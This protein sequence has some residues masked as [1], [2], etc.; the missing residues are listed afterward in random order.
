MTTAVIFPARNHEYVEE[1]MMK[2]KEMTAIA[3]NRIWNLVQSTNWIGRAV[4]ALFVAA[5]LLQS[6]A[7]PAVAQG[8]NIVILAPHPD[9]E[10]LCCA[11]IIHNAL[12]QGSSVTIVVVTNGDY[13]QGVPLGLQREAETV[14]AMSLLGLSEQQI[15]F[16]GYGDEAL[17]GLYQSSSPATVIPSPAGQT[18]TYASRGLGGISY[19]QYL[20]GTPGPYSRQTILG[21][22]EAMLQNLQP[23]DVYTTGLW[24]DHPD[25]VA[26][27]NF[28]VE[29]LLDLRRQ[30]LPLSTKIHETLV[31]A[32]CGSCGVPTNLNYLWP[33]GGTGITPTFSPTQPYPQP[34]YLSNAWPNGNTPTP[35]SWSQ[36]E[37]VPVPAPMQDP[38]QAT[39]FKANIIA[40]YKS[41]DGSDRNAYLYAFVKKNEFFWIR[42][43]STNL[44]GLATVS[45][46]TQS[47]GSGQL[48]TS[49]VDGFIE[50]FP[51]YAPWEWVTQ[52]ELAGAWINL[53]WPSPV[54]ISQVVLY[55]RQDWVDQ[56]LSG[57]L[58][59]SDNS[60]VPVGQLPIS[61]NGY[62]VSFPPK[63]VTSM[64]FTVDSGTGQNIGLTEIEVFGELAG[65]TVN[66]PQFFQ[67]PLASAPYGTDQ[68]GQLLT[69]TI[70]DSQTTNL[71]VLAFDV[72]AQ[73]LNYSWT[74]DSGIVTGSG[75]NALFKPPVVAAPTVVTTT[76]ALDDGQG[77]TAQNSTFITVTPSNTSG[78]TVS[79]L[80]VSPGSVQ[81]GST[82]LGTVTLSNVA[83]QGAVVVLSSSNTAIANVPPTVAV[84]PGATSATF[85]ISTVYVAS[86]VSVTISASLGGVT[87][88]DS[89]TVLQ[90]PVIVSSVTFNP[91]TVGGGN[92]S[93]GT[94]LLTGPAQGDAVITLTNGSPS[95]ITIPASVTVPSG[96][97]SVSFPVTTQSVSSATSVAISALYVGQ[98]TKVSLRVAPYV[99]PNLATSATVTVSSQSINTQQQGIKA[100][101]GIVDGSP[102]D[103]TEEW[104]TLGQLAGA[105]LKLSW[106][107]PVTTSQVVLYDRPNL[108][109]NVT[110]ATLSF[111]DG[112][113]VPVGTLP[114]DGSPLAVSFSPKT[115]TWMQFTVNTAV[116]QNIGL[117]EIAVMGTI[118]QAS[119]IMSLT[120]APTSVTGGNGSTGTVTLDGVAPAGGS[121]VALASSDTSTATVP[122]TVTVPAGSLAASFP[123]ATNSVAS[124]TGVSISGT[125]NGTQAALLTVVPVGISTLS[126]S[127]AMVAGGAATST[128]TVTLTGPAPPSGA[129]IA[130]TSNN[131]SVASVPATMAIPPGSTSGTFTVTTTSVVATVKVGVSAIYNGIQAATLWVTPVISGGTM[132]QFAVDNFNRNN[133]PLGSD[134]STTIESPS[135]P[136]ITSQQVQS[137]WVFSTALYYGGI[138]WPADQYAQVQVLQSNNGSSGPAVRMTS[139]AYYAGTV[140]SFGAGNANVYIILNSRGNRSIIASSSTATVLA[141]DYLQLTV[142]GTTLTLT[143]VTQSETLLTVTDSTLAAGYP[144]L[145]VGSGG[146]V[147]NWSAGL[148]AM[149]PL[150]QTI[151][152]D[153]FNRADSPNLG[154][155]WSVG[156]GY[157]PIQIISTQIE[158]D[159]QGQPPGQGHGKEYYSAATFPSDQWSQAQ[160][161]QS[162]NDIN[163]A[164]VRY[165][166]SADTHYVGFASMLGAPGTCSVAIDS[167]TNGSPTVLAADSQLCSV[168]SGDYLRLQA[169]GS[170]L[171]Y[172]DVTTG[173][174]LLTV[175]D[176]GLS[177]GYPGWSLNPIGGTP[178]AANW[179]AGQ[180]TA[181]SEVALSSLTLNP[182]SVAGGNTSSGT[183]MLNGPAPS[184]GALVT[185][186]SSNTGAAQLPASVT[187]A[188]GATTATFTIT[189]SGVASNTT[190]TISGSYGATQNAT[191]TVTAAT[192]S[193]VSVNPTSVLGGN[194]STGTVTLNG[195]APSGGAGIALSSS[196][197]SAAQVPTSVT[198]AAGATTAIFAITT[199][200]VASDTTLTISGTYG[201]TQ[202]AS[203]TVTAPRTYTI[204]GTISGP[205]GAGATV[206]L[207]GASTATTTADG[208]GN[209]SFMGLLNGSY[210]VTPS[211]TGYVF[212]PASQPVTISGASATASFSSTLQT[213]SISGTIS[214]AGGAG[215]TVS[216]TGAS[217]AVT[218][219]DGS[220]NYNFSGLLN[221]SYVVTPIKTGYVFTPVSQIVVINGSNFTGLNFSPVSGCPTCDTIWPA[222][223]LPTL[224]DSGDATATEVGVKFRADYDGYITGLRFYK[225]STNTG[226]HVG[227]LWTSTGTPLG[228]ATFTAETV[229]GWQLVLFATPIPVV[230]NTTYVASYF[231]PAGH[232]SGDSDFF[233]TA[234]VDNPPLHALANGLD[235]PDGVYLYTPTGGFPTATNQASNYWVDVVYNNGLGYSIVGTLTGPGAAGATVSLTGAFTATTTADSS[236]NYSFNRLANGSYTVTPS[237]AG[238][239][240]TPASQ[241]LT[242]NG[243]HAMS[244]NFASAPA[245][246]SITGTISGPGGAGATVN[247][248]GASTATTTA[249][250]SGN[251]SFTGLVNGSYT[252]TPTNTG[253]VFAPTSQAVTISGA[254]AVASFSSAQQTYS[255]SGTISG[256]GGAGATVNLTGTSTATTTADGSGNYSFTGLVSGSYTVTPTNTGYMFAP[257]SQAVTVSGANAAASFSST[258]QTFSISGTISG[259]GGAGATVSLTGASTAVTTA[260][261]SGNYTFNGLLNGSYAVTPTNNGYAF[262]PPSQI[263]V[264]NGSNF[265]GLNFSPV[266]G[267]PTCDTIWLATTLPT[268]ADSGDATATELGVKFRA[269]NDGYITGVRFYKASTNTGTHVGHLWTSTGTPLGS[270][271]FTGET[272]AGWQMVLFATPIPVVANTTY[273]ASYFAPAGHYSGDSNFFATA[274]VD[275]PPLH[276]LANGVAGP[277][278]VYLYSPTGG[279]PTATNQASNYWVDVVYNNGLGYSIVGT[280]TGP[281][282]AGA[283]VGLTGASTAT[284]TA[285][286][287]GNYSFNGLANGSYTVTPSNAG[288]VFTPASQTLTINGAHAMNVNFASALQTFSIS[289]TIS[290]PG[291]AGATVNLTGASTAT[292][293]A[294]GSGNYSFAGLANGAYTVTPNLSGYVY[295]PPNQTVTVSG[296][297]ISSV[298]FT[299]VPQTYTISGAIS[300]PGGAGAT[301]SLTGASTATTTAD[302]SGN[303]SFTGLASGSYTVTPSNAGFIFSPPSQSTTISGAN[304]SAFNFNSL[305]TVSSVSVS[306]ASVLG[307]NTSTGTVTLNAPAPA[308]GAVVTLSSGNN[309]A[310]Q[311]PASVTVAANATTATFTVT[312]S[313]VAGNTSLTISA[314]YGTTQTASFTVTAAVLSSVA[315]NPTSVLGGT[316]STGMVTLNG[317]AP[318]GGAVVTL[319]SSNTAAAQVPASVTVAAN[320]TSATFTV[321][322]SPVATNAS[323]TIS[324]TYGATQN[325]TFTVTAAVLSSVTVSPTSVL[326]GTSSTGTVTL[327]GPAPA[328]GAVVTLSSSNTTAAQVVPASV[329]VAANANTATFTVT[330]NPVATNTTLT[331][332]GSYG[333]TQTASFTVT[334]PVLTLLSLNPA[335]VPAGASSVGTVTLSG[336]A[337]AA[338]ALITLSSSNTA[339]AQVPATVTVAARATTV[340]FS[341][342]TS[343]VAANTTLTISGTYGATQNASFTVTSAVLSTVTLNPTSVVGGTSSTGTVTLSKVAPTGGAVVTLVSSNPA[344][345]VPASVTVAA[346]QPIASFTVTTTPVATNT[347]LTISG[348][349]GSTKT[350]ALT[351]AAPT[352]SS[353]TLSPASVIGGTSSTGTVTLNGRAPSGGAV[354]TLS[355]SNTAAAQVPASVTVAANATT[356]TFTVTTSPVATNASVT[357]T[358]TRGTTHTATLTVTAATLSTV[359]MGP[360]SVIGGTPSTGTVT[361]TGPAPSGGAVV[362]LSSS[363]TAAAQVPASVTVAA[364]ATTA[365]FTV[366]T[367]PVATNASVTIT[368]TR[369]TTHTATLTVTAAT[370]SSV[371]LNPTS[372]IGGTSSTGTVTLT[373]P[374]PSGGAVVTLSSSNTSAAKVPAS[375]TVAPNATTATFT[376][377]TSAVASNTS[378]TITGTRGTART[379]TLTVTAPTLSALTLNPT[380]VKGPAP[381]TGTVTLSGPAPTGGTVVTLSSN[382]TSVAT[383]PASVTVTAGTTTA[384]FT[385]TTHTVATSTS[386]TISATKGGTL[387]ANL[388]VTP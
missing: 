186:S 166:G 6:S 367:S 159:G 223:T 337:P 54:T 332:S 194:S 175:L 329:T 300:G 327:N 228:S 359:S 381:S 233:A 23:T 132:Q 318:A 119:T 36:I 253:Y 273:I 213:F 297:S 29:A 209:Y 263:V 215:A 90:P 214:G 16:M 330:T 331:I 374:A 67:G 74:S 135:V 86:S 205:G 168:S 357:I 107:L 277:D 55:N 108:V 68:Y 386:V 156:P 109:D 335:S 251:Y 155:N 313:P 225:A 52:G 252:V 128:G 171:T 76:V 2:D 334:P 320:A 206:N 294:D 35:Y 344:A 384:T 104:A 125:F 247:L 387:T 169:Q 306:P 338:G 380:T 316:S 111:S 101:D 364:N 240:F 272:V 43:F 358:G 183:V 284:T 315:V 260:D 307:G 317:P 178:I 289:G 226:T 328:G 323:L 245:T 254:N 200:A 102:G 232:C 97:K 303:Y 287:S 385:V 150:L 324:G 341:V 204:S 325:A 114:N 161:L 73:P 229:A 262:T 141:N 347:P 196:N 153:N 139:N 173:S 140:G 267:C 47:P 84:A 220:G 163:G 268:L 33:G 177:G 301:V 19:H 286:G 152:S 221:G 224:A 208:S 311:V 56:V 172:V 266:S 69:P 121:V 349:Y 154:P 116:G 142:Q 12:Q 348:T 202:N 248:T 365:T 11:G 256:P 355:S 198:V 246:Y 162:T 143:D 18:Q 235:G 187:V 129:V 77:G 295:T 257:T 4:L 157:F 275:N 72:D 88:T 96:T 179:S 243:A 249:D 302:G 321:T 242:I 346:G 117:A 126:L 62:L 291:G 32:P 8:K 217:T 70:T 383:V 369:S 197:T 230:A 99:P 53:T 319:S 309:A 375:V 37:S 276:A 373:G 87:Q 216:L 370:A 292:T 167:D 145:Y 105:W 110:S 282:A 24:D 201:T 326:G 322:S 41:Q 193:G 192:L 95:I 283:T 241:T 378:V 371:T 379:A 259:G 100:I 237:N 350:A 158:S 244:V 314:T 176:S 343:S 64:Q 51:G 78:L 17:Q 148:T 30:G 340:S 123:I 258:L 61:G 304:V 124:T 269:D 333:A 28:V 360:A 271:T 133:G 219:A 308:G 60:T 98:T 137:P 146:I 113:T 115:I 339:A 164:M 211:N 274:G 44:A 212:T 356:A 63:T 189:T 234:G 296:A 298:N 65:N 342:T 285:D 352:L 25:H 236:G 203:F 7:A 106:G 160:V 21:D 368:A 310:A 83:P 188:A 288:S 131:S 210:T 82:A 278:G 195:P 14:S 27:F 50:G 31:H 66:H 13:Y 3:A 34:Y 15:I 136:A 222:T 26:T 40:S 165:Q 81:S 10:A 362:T 264:I 9:D 363:N 49:A 20:Y 127:P 351:V 91:S 312:T 181:Q 238:Y 218:T 75:A 79:S 280:L 151:A 22:M 354:V 149:P 261:G 147:A 184:G 361:L 377:T 174:L 48:G 185:L 92:P 122:A 46:S 382:L 58:T 134:W 93:N 118:T 265:T 45:E 57:H 85:S 59:F 170:L 39:N 5:I 239:V 80:Y 71:S 180:F 120:V 1:L 305:P 376:V 388:T 290:G 293:T 103:Y 191:L 231:A 182:T 89:V 255:I 250:S 270:A 112:T 345:Q 366:T 94:V 353:V 279:F 144:G 42:D 138:N 207:T 199:S 38:N 130:L 227:H 336:P 372:V 299:S 190:A 281:G